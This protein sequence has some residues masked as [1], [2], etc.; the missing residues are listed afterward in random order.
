[1]PFG[2]N[3]LRATPERCPE[4][5]AVVGEATVLDAAGKPAG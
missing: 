2:K 4:R 3:D 1:M 5:G